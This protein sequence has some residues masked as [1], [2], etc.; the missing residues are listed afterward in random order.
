M[1]NLQSF[2]EFLNES[3]SYSKVTLK[4]QNAKIV[5]LNGNLFQ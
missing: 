5:E 1:K 3:D 2:D 4:L